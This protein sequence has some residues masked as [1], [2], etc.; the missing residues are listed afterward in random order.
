MN[1]I[2][3]DQGSR[4][5]ENEEERSQ[6]LFVLIP[7]TMTEDELH[8]YFKQFGDIDNIAIIRDR[9]TKENK[10]FAYVKYFKLVL[11]YILRM[12]L[13]FMGLISLVCFF[14]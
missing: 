5:E 10:G 12:N 4:R 3:R 1:I 2:R 8:E 13:K 11:I 7:K 9:E 6:R 14:S